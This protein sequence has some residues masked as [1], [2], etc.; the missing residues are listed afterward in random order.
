[1]SEPLSTSAEPAQAGDATMNWGD[2]APAAPEAPAPPAEPAAAPTDPPAE[3]EPTPD[4]PAEPA[5]SAPVDDFTILTLQNG[6]KEVRLASGAVYRGKT[7]A[8]LIQNLAKAKFHADNTLR[9]LR[10]RSVEPPTPA[11]APAPAANQATPEM[12]PATI[13][14]ADMMAPALGLK[15]GQELV[16]AWRQM[17]EKV[18]SYEQQ[19]A[20]MQQNQIAGEFIRE[21]GDF[22]VT[23]GNIDRFSE[24]FERTGLPFTKENALLVHHAMKGM[25]AYEKVEARQVANAA[26]DTTPRSPDGKFAARMPL[27]PAPSNPAPAQQSPDIW[28]MPDEDFNKYL[29]ETR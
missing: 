14:V 4:A 18:Q 8:E 15:N 23:P 12:D 27:P 29:I 10:Q 9:D 22:V 20:A 21:A 16:Q 5:Q 2:P 24:Q 28:A 17:N 19:A 1:M 3:P 6:E 7:D 25:G 11:P 26:P 13:A